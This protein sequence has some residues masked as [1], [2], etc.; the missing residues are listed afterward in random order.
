MI[1][2][3][4]QLQLMAV[5]NARSSHHVVTPTGGGL[6]F[7]VPVLG[8]LVYLAVWLDGALWPLPVMLA[9]IAAVGLADDVRDLGRAAR[10][11]VQVLVVGG[12]LWMVPEGGLPLL[13]VAGVA[14]VWFVNLYNFM[15]GIDGI[16]G[17]QFLF[18]A[19]AVLWL[20]EQRIVWVSELLWFACA[21]VAGFMVFNW[22]RARV[23]MGDVG[24]GFL[25]L[26]VAAVVWLLWRT[27]Q[28]PLVAL[29]ILL[30]GFW[31]DATYTICV[32]IVT[33]Q[34]FAQAHRSHLYQVIALRKG[35]LWTTMTFLAF[36]LL[37][38]LPAAW[39]A[40]H[41]PA[42]QWYAL[43][44]AIAPLFA[45]AVLLGAGKMQTA[46]GG[47]GDAAADAPAPDS[48]PSADTPSKQDRTGG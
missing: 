30:A 31:F 14:M 43:V 45:G 34:R 16:A 26:L 37:W 23:F 13:L 11:L 25:G 4:V 29:L 33:R 6:G 20:S 3:G 41:Y 36:C 7:V 2:Y 24:S 5:P 32:R 28:V 9:L 44:A 21:A 17:V 46:T 40:V 12:V 8:F 18:F 39:I 42:W 19:L 38:L 35:H 27:G 15:D 22:P 48:N 1:Q 10:L 47:V